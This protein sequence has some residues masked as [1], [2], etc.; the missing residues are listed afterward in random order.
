M[1]RHDFPAS[2]MKEGRG[3]LL[4]SWCALTHGLEFV[5][6]ANAMK[7]DLASLSRKVAN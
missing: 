6:L 1:K 2:Q 4:N 5:A 7:A 3:V